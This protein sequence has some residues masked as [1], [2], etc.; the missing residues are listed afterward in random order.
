VFLGKVP[1]YIFLLE[2]D[3][4]H[5]HFHNAQHREVAPIKNFLN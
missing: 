2:N 3:Q 5:Y 1:V 4:T